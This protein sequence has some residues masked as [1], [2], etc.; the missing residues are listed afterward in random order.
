MCYSISAKV[1]AKQWS[2]IQKLYKKLTTN[3][4]EDGDERPMNFLNV[5][6]DQHP[7]IPVITQQAPEEVQLY[8]WGV[9][10]SFAKYIEDGDR[11]VHPW[12]RPNYYHTTANA[13]VESLDTK[14]TWKRLYKKKRCIIIATGFFE[15]YHAPGIK[16]TYPHYIHLKNHPVFGFAGLYDSWIDPETS[17]VVNTCAIIST[18]PNE[19]MSKI[20]NNPKAY[21]GPR[22]PVMLVPEEW[23]SWL[24]GE[25]D[26]ESVKSFAQPLDSEEMNAYPVLQGLMK[27]DVNANIA[28]VLDPVEFPEL[29]KHWSNYG[30]PRETQSSLF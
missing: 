13:R 15:F 2:E 21:D 11:L 6:K 22:C 3:A 20:H 4:L 1:S 18:K 8:R 12:T 26:Y 17:E 27:R 14:S 28:Q 16:K 24:E 30:K 19:M 25:L 23:S 29:P 7:E 9:I 5:Y 10:P